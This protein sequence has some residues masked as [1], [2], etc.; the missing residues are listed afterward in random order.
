MALSF[1]Y[2]QLEAALKAWPKDSDDDYAAQIP[3]IID[4]GELRLIREL[5]I[6]IFDTR[7]SVF[8]N[9][10][11]EFVL[12]PDNTIVVRDV[13]V[14]TGSSWDP[15][16]LRSPSF[17]DLYAPD[18]SPSGWGKPKYYCEASST[19]IKL[20]PRPNTSMNVIM[21]VTKRPTDSLSSSTPNA[22]SWLSRTVPDCL[23]AACLME[24]EHYLKADDRYGDYKSKYYGELIPA[25]R[26]ELRNSI[27]RGDHSPLMAVTPPQ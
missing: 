7:E 20:A 24:A 8:T 18:P 26:T 19:Q 21:R 25:A 16:E 15:V 22:S 2:A 11:A 9:A 1:T 6:E 23:F 10:G 4:M 27:R 12:K 17:C 14:N 5:N 13:S 3:R